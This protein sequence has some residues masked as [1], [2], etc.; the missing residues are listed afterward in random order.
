MEKVTKPD[1][2]S[3]HE[4]A[5]D[6]PSLN[7]E[8]LQLTAPRWKNDEQR[9]QFFNQTFLNFRGDLKLQIKEVT[10]MIEN[11]R[12][13]TW[14]AKYIVPDVFKNDQTDFL[15]EIVQAMKDNLFYGKSND[16]LSLA[17]QM[18]NKYTSVV[19]GQ[20]LVEETFLHLSNVKLTDKDNEHLPRI[21]QEQVCAVTILRHLHNHPESFMLFGVDPGSQGEIDELTH[22]LPRMLEI[23]DSIDEYRDLASRITSYVNNN[24][25]DANEY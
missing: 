17:K 4:F 8:Q 7:F 9:R 19:Y 21:I 16:I 18:L 3:V 6:N 23:L 25:K 13:F 22:D 14:N 15:A 12:W 1:G 5:R 20:D 2:M 11:P 24:G 10:Y